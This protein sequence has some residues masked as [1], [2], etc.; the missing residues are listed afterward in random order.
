M[1]NESVAQRVEIYDVTL[2]DGAQGPG[3]KF[4]S[5]DQLRIVQELDAFGIS[6]I[7]GGQPG[8]NPKAAE[9]FQRAKDLDLKYAVMAA[10]GSTRHAKYAVEDDPNIRALLAADTP[11]V[12]IFAR[13]VLTSC[14]V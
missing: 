8:S 1:E 5:E 3:V 6:C 13:M 10:F 12:T 4:S 9:L 14:G 7:E 2:R 11:V